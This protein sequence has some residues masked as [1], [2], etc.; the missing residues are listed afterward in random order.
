MECSFMTQENSYDWHEKNRATIMNSYQGVAVYP[1]D[2]GDI[3]IRSEKSEFQEE[4]QIVIVPRIYVD[5]VVAAMLK[6]K[7]ELDEEDA[8]D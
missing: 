8:N 3:V 7:E 1:N 4:D 5:W 2:R 6:E